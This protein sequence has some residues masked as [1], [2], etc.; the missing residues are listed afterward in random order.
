MSGQSRNNP[1]VGA[2]S[3]PVT[4]M[5]GPKFLGLELPWA[6]AVTGAVLLMVGSLNL[7][8]FGV[9]F[10]PIMNDFGWS[11]GAVGAAYTVRS[12][13]GLLSLVFGYLADRHGQKMFVL[14]GYLLLGACFL[15]NSRIET[16]WQLYLVQAGLGLGS[17][18][19]FVAVMSTVAKWHDKRRGLALG[20]CAAGIGVS[21]LIFAPV[22]AK[23]IQS[24]GWRTASVVLGI[25]T[26]AIAIPSALAMK[27]PPRSPAKDSPSSSKGGAL[28]Q[29]KAMPR[30]LANR[31]F[32]VM[33][34]PFFLMFV[35]SSLVSNH[36][37]NYA[38]DIGISA[39]IAAA[40]VSV[41]GVAGTV[42]RLGMGAFS[43]RIGV[44][45]DLTICCAL[46]TVGI[47]I[48]VTR[49]PGLMWLGVGLFGIGYGGM[50][51]LM[52]GL[53]GE[54]FGTGELATM[55]S[56]TTVATTLGTALGPW[57]GGFMFDTW[58]TYQGA[59]ILAASFAAVA[60][61]IAV[62]LPPP[63]RVDRSPKKA[64]AIT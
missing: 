51:P 64:G 8:T 7:A 49:V 33:T 56:V 1:Q 55:T 60:L 22:T 41:S 63:V 14:P 44:K 18:F 34:I 30:M 46:S 27:D 11:R 10:K 3:G 58:N 59:L 19:P 38:T 4:P 52:T 54:Y 6:M 50:V 9:F 62:R 28:E 53:V 61:L 40:M 37:V 12:L 25:V 36:L 17:V 39:L 29:M 35:G 2:N 13:V 21:S 24:Y 5:S 31:L 32:L 45:N 43:D 42:G 20:I 23:L 57:L 26:F 16:L 48:L 15:L 47:A